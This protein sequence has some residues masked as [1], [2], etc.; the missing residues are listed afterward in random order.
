MSISPA[1]G[2]QVRKRAGCTCEYCGVTETDSGGL[3]TVDHFQPTACGGKDDLDNLIY[4]CVRCNLYKAAFSSEDAVGASIWNPRTESMDA[5][6]LELA[7][8]LLYP[9]TPAGKRTIDCMRLNRS[10]LVA[11]RIR[12]LAHLSAAKDQ[13]RLRD[14]LV[15]LASLVEQHEDRTKQRHGLRQ[16]LRNILERYSQET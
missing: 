6:F 16:Q 8:G 7:N 15:L 5:H 4:C 3:L 2:Q 14:L 13:G 1:L 10:A 11:N 9:I 12:R